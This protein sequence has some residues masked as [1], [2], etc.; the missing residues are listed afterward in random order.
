MKKDNYRLV[1]AGMKLA[2]E[3]FR[4]ATK[5]LALLG[6]IFNYSTNND[7]TLGLKI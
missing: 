6:M 4:F 2:T 7:T 1:L 3:F 5:L